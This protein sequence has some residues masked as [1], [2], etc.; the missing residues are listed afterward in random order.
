VRASRN[1]PDYGGCSSAVERRTV[2]PEVAGSNPVIHP[3]SRNA[4]NKSAGIFRFWVETANQQLTNAFSLSRTAEGR[5]R[6]GSFSACFELV[7]RSVEVRTRRTTN[8]AAAR[9]S[10]ERHPSAL[11]AGRGRTCRASFQSSCVRDAAGRH[12]PAL[13]P[14]RARRPPPFFAEHQTVVPIN[15]PVCHFECRR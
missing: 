9:S 14:F 1:P 8:R 12:A 11:R 2:A 6:R 3:N 7:R 15:C 13:P 4:P 10:V 5:R